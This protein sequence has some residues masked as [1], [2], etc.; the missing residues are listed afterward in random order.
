LIGRLRRLEAN[1]LVTREPCQFR[2]VRPR[3][4]LTAAG[5]ELGAM[6]GEITSWCSRRLPETHTSFPARGD[7]GS[8]GAPEKRGPP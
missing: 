1:G 2:P 5:Q 3:Y 4:C 6:L 7:S 8:D